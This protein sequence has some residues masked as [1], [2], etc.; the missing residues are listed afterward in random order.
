MWSIFF[1]KHKAFSLI[2]PWLLPL[3]ILQPTALYYYESSLFNSHNITTLIILPYH[4]LF[5]VETGKRKNTINYE[6]EQ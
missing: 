3:F 5:G 4:S 2:L 6:Q 1:V